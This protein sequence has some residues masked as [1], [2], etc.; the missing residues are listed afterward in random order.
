MELIPTWVWFVSGLL[1]LVVELNTATFFF[2]IV[3]V[4]ALFA[5]LTDLFFSGELAA[6]IVFIIG[7]S[8]AAYLAWKL[9]I[10]STTSSGIK[11]GADRLIGKIGIV[12]ERVNS[13]LGTG[14]IRVE[15]EKWRAKS[16]Q[17]KIIDEGREVTVDDIEGTTLVVVPEETHNRTE[18]IEEDEK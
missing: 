14:I 16:E 6:F 17:D 3:G 5:S 18:K 8:L 13:S 1:F 12:E 9:N 10:Y 11:T 2:G 4:G 15:G 7:S